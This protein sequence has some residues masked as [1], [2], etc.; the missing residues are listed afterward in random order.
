MAARSSAGCSIP[1]HST[2]LSDAMRARVVTAVFPAVVAAFVCAVVAI[3][4]VAWAP[5]AA[6]AQE[7]PGGLVNPQR[8]CQTILQCNFR[9]GGVYRGC[10]SAY[11]CRR[12]RFV[13][14]R[15]SVG[16]QSRNCRQVRCT[17]G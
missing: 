2:R 9:R 4:G 3:A 1:G 7:G 6:L 10:I 5:A 17:W 15:C 12:C 11:S 13:P 16:R 14:A 8:D